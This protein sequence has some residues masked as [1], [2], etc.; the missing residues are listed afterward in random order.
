M[1]QIP[2]NNLAYPVMIEAGPSTGSGFFLKTISGIYLV[3]ASHVLFDETSGALR[4]PSAR[5][6]CYP[7]GGG[8]GNKTEMVVDLEKAFNMHGVQ[9]DRNLDVCAILI[10]IRH[11][12]QNQISYPVWLGQV[13]IAKPGIVCVPS[14]GV[15]QSSEVLISNTVFIFGYPVSLGLPNI[16]QIDPSKPLLRAGIVAGRNE[17]LKTLI[18][19]CPVYPGNSGGPVLEV[20]NQGLNTNYR[21]IGVVTQFVPTVAS[22]QGSAPGAAIVNSGYSVVAPMDGVMALIAVLDSALASQGISS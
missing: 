7:E 21:V 19:D 2:E 16:P 13:S 4:S 14:D 11:I 5:L 22:V 3:T 15:K 6:I 10:F 1:R 20:D 8:S 17:T 18:L 12:D 9:L